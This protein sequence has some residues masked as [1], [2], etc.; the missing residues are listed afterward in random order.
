MNQRAGSDLKTSAKYVSLLAG[1][2]II[3]EVSQQ[4]GVYLRLLKTCRQGLCSLSSQSTPTF[5]DQ[6]KA[7]TNI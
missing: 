5:L 3:H 7:F 2:K 4:M 1:S 6:R